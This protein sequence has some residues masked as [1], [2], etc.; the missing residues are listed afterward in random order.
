MFIQTFRVCRFMQ[1]F[2]LQAFPTFRPN[3]KGD[4]LGLNSATMELRGIQALDNLE[5]LLPK[6][7]NNTIE[8]R[9]IEKKVSD[10]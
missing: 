5:V 8:E 7:G 9:G 2:Y 6:S 10:L 3:K 4:P 1:F